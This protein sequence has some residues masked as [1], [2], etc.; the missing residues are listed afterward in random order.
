MTA[1]CFF[2]QPVKPR[3]KIPIYV[4]ACRLCLLVFAEPAVI[5]RDGILV[6]RG[7]RSGIAAAYLAGLFIVQLTPQLQLKL[8]HVGEYLRV[9]LFD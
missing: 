9:E 1:F 4:M 6:A 8:V 5:V 3:P 2:P 7:H